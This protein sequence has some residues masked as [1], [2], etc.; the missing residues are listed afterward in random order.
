VI[1]AP[2][3]CSRDLRAAALLTCV[4]RSTP[5]RAAVH[6]IFVLLDLASFRTTLLTHPALISADAGILYLVTLILVARLVANHVVQPLFAPSS[7][8]AV[9]ADTTA[10]KV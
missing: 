4:H 2:L 3:L 9:V 5:A 7:A 6:Y 10:K 8:S 1:S